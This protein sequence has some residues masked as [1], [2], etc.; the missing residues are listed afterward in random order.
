MFSV[1]Q[2]QQC[3]DVKSVPMS[4]RVQC[5]TVEDTDMSS[6]HPPAHQPPLPSRKDW[7]PSCRE[8]DLCRQRPP[9]RS[10]PCWGDLGLWCLSQVGCEGPGSARCRQLGQMARLIAQ[11]ACC[12][13]CRAV[14]LLPLSPPPS[15]PFLSRCRS[16]KTWLVLQIQSQP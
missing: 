8:C 5:T 13:G 14:H 12:V 16:L 3:A 1:G 15:S 6:L 2:I 10:G 7:G 11:S 4:A 9:P